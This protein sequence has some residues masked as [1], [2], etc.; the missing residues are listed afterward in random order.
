MKSHARVAVIGGGVVGCSVLYHLTKLG[1]RDVVLIERKELTAG[2]SW[3]AAGGF[4]ALNSDP[5]IARLQSYTI[6]LYK[7]IQELSG[8]DVGMHMTGGLTIAGT[9]ERWEFLKADQARHR[10]LGLDT[11]LL[12]PSEVKALCPIMDVTNVVGAIYDAHEGHIDPSGVTYAYA[13]AA[14]VNGAEIYR[15]TRVM[16]LKPTGRGGWRVITDQGEIEAEH[17]VNAAG[18]WAREMGALVGVKLPLIPMEHQYL[19]TDDIPEVA[20]L[21]KELPVLVDLDAEI[22]MRQERNGVLAGVYEKDARP[23]ALKGTPWDYGDTEL[24]P[25]DLDRLTDALLKGFERLPSVAEA[26]IRR[27][28]NGPFTFTP[29]G[30]PLVGPVQGVPNYWSACGVMAGFAQA[31]GVGLTLAQWIVDGE[32]DGEVFAMDVARFGP[33]ATESYVIDKAREFYSNRFRL[34]YPNEY[35]PAGRPAK[36]DP[37]YDVLK[38]R[39]AVFGVNWG[40]EAPLYFAPPGE[41]AVELPAISRSNAFEVVGD[42]VR[43]VQ[44]GVGVFDICAFA[45]YEV[46]GPGAAEWLDTVLANSL[47]AVG[48]VRLAPLLSPSGRLMGDLTVMR[49]AEDRFM[50]FGSGYLQAW[51]M[52]WFASLLP[53]SGVSLVNRTDE[54]G[55]LTLAGPRSRELLQR[56]TRADVGAEAFRFLSLVEADVGLAPTMIARLSLTGEQTFEIYTPANQLRAVYSALRA[57]GEDLGLVDFGVHALLSMR[58]EKSLGVWG[59]EFSRDYTPAMCGLDRFVDAKK[60]GF[61]GRDAF[62]AEVESPPKQVLATFA[63]EDGDADAW[64]Y[65]PIRADGEHVGFATSGGFGHRVQRSLVMGYVDRAALGAASFEIPILGRPRKAELLTAPA[66]DPSGRLMRS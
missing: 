27:I 48:R 25:P 10:V 60:P 52:R 35:W 33:F 30:N 23:W 9:Q 15:H 66:Y 59:R 51:H 31:G 38:D 58:L 26:G 16:D 57:A 4:H 22:Y 65:E 45:K 17:V 24:L 53:P 21:G 54:I 64:G 1:W 47:P 39:N 42:E 43:A 32:P 6:R 14:R 19:V 29:D 56:V 63:L 3:H 28:V 12:A 5:G 44:Q 13:K 62:L 11:Q 46:S 7:E 41:P 40:L 2:S 37:L 55:G 18:L 20:A 34:A 49:P 61:I 50:L 36:T 8:Q